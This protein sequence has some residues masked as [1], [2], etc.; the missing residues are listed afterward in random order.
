[1]LSFAARRQIAVGKRRDRPPWAAPVSGWTYRQA[2]DRQRAL[3]RLRPL[4]QLSKKLSCRD[5]IRAICYVQSVPTF[6]QFGF[7]VASTGGADHPYR[8][9]RYCTCFVGVI[10]SEVKAPEPLTPF[11]LFWACPLDCFSSLSSKSLAVGVSTVLLGALCYVFY[12]K[13]WQYDADLGDVNVPDSIG[14]TITCSWL[15]VSFGNELA[16]GVTATLEGT[17]SR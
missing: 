7:T 17:A 1:M 6:T 12:L 10:L 2:P 9:N 3:T 8:P 4:S 16:T 14:A 15:S 11:S 13:W 5:E